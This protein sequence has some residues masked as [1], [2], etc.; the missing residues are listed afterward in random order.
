MAH[1]HEFPWQSP[2]SAPASPTGEAAPVADES[3]RRRWSGRRT[4]GVALALTTTLLALSGS[5]VFRKNPGSDATKNRATGLP[6]AAAPGGQNV[7]PN[8]DLPGAGA[9]PSQVPENHPAYDDSHD[10]KCTP[11]VTR[12]DGTHLHVRPKLAVA[13]NPNPGRFATVVEV[14]T[15]DNP[16][17]FD[18]KKTYV[19]PGLG[20]AVD[21]SVPAN[22]SFLNTTATVSLVYWPGTGELPSDPNAYSMGANDPN[23]VFIPCGNAVITWLQA[24]GG[25][26]VPNG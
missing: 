12:P 21:V 17:R 14:L 9:P 23:R 26:T 13:G 3:P 22:M 1:V 18:K 11:D 25:I 19:A 20:T 8:K 15:G 6:P 2:V 5:T 10:V 4:G 7:N 16:A 24:N